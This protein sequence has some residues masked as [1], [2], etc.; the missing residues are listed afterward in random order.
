MTQAHR[1]K[2]DPNLKAHSATN[3]PVKKKLRIKLLC[4]SSAVCSSSGAE[5]A[6]TVI[7]TTNADVSS[8]L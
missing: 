4:R 8:T 3:P 5:G 2:R 1:M 6:K 7:K